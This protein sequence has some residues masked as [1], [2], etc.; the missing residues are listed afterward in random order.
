MLQPLLEHRDRLDDVEALPRAGGAG[1][2]RHPLVA[3]VQRLEDLVADLHLLDRI[4]READAQRVPDAHPQQVSKADRRLD[5]AGDPAAGFRHAQ[6]QRRVGR[7]RHRHVGGRGQEH[8]RRLQADLVLAEIVVLE[9]P[10]MAQAALDH[11]LGA[12]LGIALQQVAL[13]RACVDAD[14]DGTAVVLGGLHH[15]A[16]LGVRADVARVDAQAGG[17]GLGGLDGALVVEV[18]VRDDRHG[19]GRDDGLERLRGLLVGAG[20][21]HDVGPRLG[22][23][24]HLGDGAADVRGQGVGHGL[25]RDRGVAADLDLAHADLAAGAAGDVAPGSDAHAGRPRPVA[26]EGRATPWPVAPQHRRSP[27]S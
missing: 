6:V 1:D 19:A 21:A 8:V 23:G 4:G 5:R 3:Q 2:D 10:D 13:E 17:A 22:A 25:D 20:D 16:H 9:Q 14:A 18:D 27:L 15:L 7:V 11:R 12:G 24:A 26:R